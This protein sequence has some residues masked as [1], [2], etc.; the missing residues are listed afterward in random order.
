M[1]RQRRILGRKSLPMEGI[2]KDW[3]QLYKR[4]KVLRPNPLQ[5]LLVFPVKFGSHQLVLIQYSTKPNNH[6]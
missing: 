1:V 3:H 5:P 6:G 4:P 2:Y